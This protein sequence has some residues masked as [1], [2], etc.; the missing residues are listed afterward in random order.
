MAKKPHGLP[1]QAGTRAVPWLPAT[2][3]RRNTMMNENK[4]SGKKAVAILAGIFAGI[5]LIDAAITRLTEKPSSPPPTPGCAQI[6]EEENALLDRHSSAEDAE[7]KAFLAEAGR[8]E[9]SALSETEKEIRLRRLVEK[10][11]INKTA[12]DANSDVTF[13]RITRKLK[14]AGCLEK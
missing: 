7:T 10:D 14:E 13:I 3:L 6:L 4:M 8:I 11:D 5:L 1:A 9:R 12:R 2:R